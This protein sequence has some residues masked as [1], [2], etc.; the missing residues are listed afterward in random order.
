MKLSSH[1]LA[2]VLFLATFELA[3]QDRPTLNEAETKFKE[4][5][6]NCTMEG[7]WT[8]LEDGALGEEKR[9]KYT[10]I[11]ANKLSADKWVIN[12]KMKYGEREMTIPLPVEVKWAGTTP[13]LIVDNLQIPGGRS[14]SARV[15]FYE[16]TYAGSWKGGDKGGLL[17]GIIIKN[18]E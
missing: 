18:K 3:A 5:L 17:S 1:F 4:L 8:P 7:R 2:I 16:K 13:V 15:L 10:I 6:T 14:Y 12:A 9:D 11:S